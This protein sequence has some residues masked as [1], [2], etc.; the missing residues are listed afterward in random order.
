MIRELEYRTEDA[1]GIVRALRADKDMTQRNAWHLA[2]VSG[3]ELPPIA[4][5]G[6]ATFGL[7]GRSYQGI[8]ISARE[9]EAALYADGE[10]PEGLRAMLDEVPFLVSCNDHALCLLRLTNDAGEVFRIKAKCM[11]LTPEK[12]YRRSVLFG[13]VFDCPVP[14]F[15][16]DTLFRV[17]FVAVEGGKEYP[18]ERPYTFGN[19]AASGST[20]YTV[21]CF[22][23][24]D[25]ASP[26]VLKLYG[27]GLSAV[28]FRNLTTGARIVLN[29]MRVAELEA[30]TDPDNLYTLAATSA[31]GS[32]TD[33]TAYVNPNYPLADFWLAPGANSIQVTMTATS[34]QPAGSCI[35]WR[36]RFSACL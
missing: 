15:E 2:K 32:M 4:S 23:S 34:V 20:S 7:A 11:E 1:R 6:S 25:V 24:G 19:V 13:A 35:E 27:S 33:A 5:L 18:L 26:C 12:Q 8:D 10:S 14:Y 16:T 28:T 9:I 31:G 3:N 36:G 22:N 30:S 21:T 29:G 17:P